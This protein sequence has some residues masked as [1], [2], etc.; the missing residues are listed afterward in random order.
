MCSSDLDLVAVK[1]IDIKLCG[2]VGY[3]LHH[4]GVPYF[5]EKGQERSCMG[6]C[7]YFR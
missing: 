6:G 3:G 5:V 2:A 1:S 4:V 7:M